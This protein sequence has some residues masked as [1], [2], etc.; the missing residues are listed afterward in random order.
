A[1][2][3]KSLS[4]TIAPS[5]VITTTSPL[6]PTTVNVPKSVAFAA[7]G[8]A[9]PFTWTRTAGTLPPGLA[10]SSAG[11]LSGAPTTGGTFGFTLRATDSNGVFGTR[12]FSL[13]VNPAPSITTASPL[14]GGSLTAPFSLA[15]AESGGTAPF[16]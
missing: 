7:T 9:V 16:S 4:I 2:A 15:F 11:V 6:P 3:S 12:D 5:P 8:G 13:T 14:P 1:N 10:L